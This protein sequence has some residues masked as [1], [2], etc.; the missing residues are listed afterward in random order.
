MTKFINIVKSF[1]ADESGAVS[2]EYAVLLVLIAA[3]LITA[4]AFLEG[5]ISNAMTDVGTCIA[6]G[7]PLNAAC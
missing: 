5:S 7:D 3:G 1:T 6:S 2:S 4:V